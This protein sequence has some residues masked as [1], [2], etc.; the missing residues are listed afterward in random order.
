[1]AAT[2]SSGSGEEERGSDIKIRFSLSGGRG[3][4][5][6]D[7]SEIL[8]SPVPP[9]VQTPCGKPA[10]PATDSGWRA[11]PGK[12]ARPAPRKSTGRPGLRKKGL[13]ECPVGLLQNAANTQQS[14]PMLPPQ[15]PALPFLGPA[16]RPFDPDDFILYN[17][18][19]GC[20]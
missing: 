6:D 14:Y 5:Q 13:F 12:K 16:L 3:R 9:P 8:D 17:H 1:M 20:L 11:F 18:P 19:V 10:G 4:M 15:G 2:S 7:L